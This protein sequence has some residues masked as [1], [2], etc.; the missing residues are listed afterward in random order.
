MSDEDNQ[1]GAKKRGFFGRLFGGREAEPAPAQPVAETQAAQT[2]EAAPEQPAESKS[3]WRRLKEGLARS[4]SSI[5]QG[6]ADVF[7]KRKLDG[8]MLDELEDIL[9][10]ADLGVATALRIREA[11]GKGRYDKQIEP[12]EV[13]AILAS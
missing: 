7:T 1:T 2:P 13:K 3:W 12:D 4:S 6:I 9:I 10:Q 5:S 11:V 8:A